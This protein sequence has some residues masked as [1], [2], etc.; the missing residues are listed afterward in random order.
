MFDAIVE[1]WNIFFVWAKENGDVLG[2]VGFLFAFTTV[3]L[4]NGRIILQRVKGGPIQSISPNAINVSNASSVAIVDAPPPMPEY[5]GKTPI[6]VLPPKEMGSFDDHFADG[7]V[8]DLIADL[9]RALFATPETG[10]VARMLEA[11]A[12]TAK[13]ARDLGVKHVLTT[14]IRRQDDRIRV[15]AQLI[16]PSGAVLWSDRFN[17]VGDDIMAIQESIA[18][19]VAKE[20]TAQLK[21]TAG[22]KNPETGKPFKSRKEA[23]AAVSSPKNRLVALML[24]FPPLGILGIHRYYV[25]RPFT[26]IL[27]TFTGGL[28]IFGWLIDTVLITLG[29]FA[30]GK[31]RALRIWRHDPLKQTKWSA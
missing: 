6:A 24:C 5:G 15:A 19:K 11:G 4:T 13:I 7:L 14:S 8:E 18:S 25:G 23:L 12:D 30:D 10:V 21:P 26:G 20:V 29:M 3:V 16:D 27:Y 28:V 2:T 1:A 9:Q 17:A 22:L 31:G